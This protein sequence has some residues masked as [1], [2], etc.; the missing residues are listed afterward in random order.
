MPLTVYIKDLVV[1]GKHGV[2]DHEKEN[3]Q[4]FS[5][6]VELSIT[7]SKAPVSDN[8]T[9]TVDWSRLKKDIIKI[10]QDKSYDLMERLAQ[11][12]AAKMLEDKRVRKTA[13]T[14]DKIDAF[15]SGMPGVR[16]EVDQS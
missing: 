12:I 16:L 5:V 14:I 6:T 8:L 9:D 1:A 15:E 3:P 13:V 4:C 11:E 7:G 2:H 10:V